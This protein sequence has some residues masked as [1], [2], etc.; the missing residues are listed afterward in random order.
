MANA[1]DCARYR[2]NLQTREISG[3]YSTLCI[4]TS[5]KYN[6][7]TNVESR[8]PFD[9]TDYAEHAVPPCL[10]GSI[11]KFSYRI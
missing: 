1:P 6:R 9:F 7:W 8:R 10:P 2:Q 4:P 3:P 11:S 5:F